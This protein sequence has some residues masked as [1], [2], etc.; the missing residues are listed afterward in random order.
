MTNTKTNLVKVITNFTPYEKQI[1]GTKLL[2]L[3]RNILLLAYCVFQFYP[4][5]NSFPYILLCISRIQRIIELIKEIK[6]K[7]LEIIKIFKRKRKEL[8][9]SVVSSDRRVFKRLSN[10]ILKIFNTNF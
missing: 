8:E 3:L 1:I 2:S 4:F 7:V 6:K 5:D 10:N 9:K